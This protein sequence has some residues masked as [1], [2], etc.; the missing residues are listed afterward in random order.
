M[1]V[2]IGAFMLTLLLIPAISLRLALYRHRYLKEMLHTLSVMDT[3]WL[4]IIVPVM[5]HTI[6]LTG[7]H[8]LDYEVNMI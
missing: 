2:A 1:N 4:F 3:M 7:F 6:L 8:L 5:T